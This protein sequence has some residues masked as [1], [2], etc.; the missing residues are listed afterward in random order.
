[1]DDVE[2][3]QFVCGYLL[4]AGQHAAGEPARAVTALIPP[5]E[6]RAPIMSPLDFLAISAMLR[7]HDI[8]ISPT[9]F[10]DASGQRVRVFAPQE[11]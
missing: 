9:I 6:G 10:A 7:L 8:A 3:L 11:A 5:I 4:A 2:W 1:V